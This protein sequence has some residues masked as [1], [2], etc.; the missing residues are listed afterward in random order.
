MLLNQPINI[1]LL[2]RFLFWWIDQQRRAKRICKVYLKGLCPCFQLIHRIPDS[3]LTAIL[4]SSRISCPRCLIHIQQNETKSCI[5]FS[6]PHVM[7]ILLITL[8]I[9][10]K[11]EFLPQLM[12]AHPNTW[13][14]HERSKRWS[15]SKNSAT[16]QKRSGQQWHE[17]SSLRL[18]LQRLLRRYECSKTTSESQRILRLKLPEGPSLSQDPYQPYLID[19]NTESCWA[20]TVGATGQSWNHPTQT[21]WRTEMSIGSPGSEE[22][23]KTKCLLGTQFN[24]LWHCAKQILE[25]W[26]N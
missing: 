11:I 13:L 7:A 18:Q 8:D 19:V 1:S 10:Q 20:T 9:M 14:L 23:W 5:M 12:R 26:R 3:C 25:T 4:R 24:N 21:S 15:T 6:F 16:D 22:F 2:Y 17:K